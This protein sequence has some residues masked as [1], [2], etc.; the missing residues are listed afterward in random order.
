[1]EYKSEGSLKK[2]AGIIG[3]VIKLDKATRQKTRLRFA[4]VLVEMKINDDFLEE[5]HFTNV[6]DELVTQQVVYKRKSIMCTK[7]NKMGHSEQKCKWNKGK[8]KAPK[9]D[10][11]LWKDK[12]GFQLV[13]R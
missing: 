3:N 13:V 7:C 8:D 10:N 6:K 11:R 5:I 9:K 4:R 12:D 1:M 2:I